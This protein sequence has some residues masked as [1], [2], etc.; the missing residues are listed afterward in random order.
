LVLYPIFQQVSTHYVVGIQGQYS[1]FIDTNP[2]VLYNT[3]EVMRMTFQ[4][5]KEAKGLIGFILSTPLIMA[6]ISWLS[7]PEDPWFGLIMFLI[8][9][10]LCVNY[11]ITCGRTIIMS[12]DGCLVKLLWIQKFYRWD[13]FKT[14][15]YEEYWVVPPIERGSPY[16]KGAIFCPFKLRRT[17]WRKAA[18]RAMYSP[19]AFAHVYVY[20]QPVNSSK[21]YPTAFPV[22]YV[23]DETEF[24]QKMAQ[25]GVSLEEIPR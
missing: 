12:Q 22:Y 15:R 18:S 8:L 13:D 2:C 4:P 19:V 11:G 23:A 7:F 3:C 6:I 1:G 9:L 14:R 16:E 21:P 24:R 5:S 20:F 25:W 17:P 10:P